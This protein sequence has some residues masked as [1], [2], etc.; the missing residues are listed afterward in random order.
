MRIEGI[1]ELAGRILVK[2]ELYASAIPYIELAQNKM[3]TYFKNKEE[4]LNDI[5]EKSEKVEKLIKVTINF[6]KQFKD[7][8]ARRKCERNRLTKILDRAKKG[9]QR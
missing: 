7:L 2:N 8:E 5:Q 9:S 4:S 6:E 1:A 3:E